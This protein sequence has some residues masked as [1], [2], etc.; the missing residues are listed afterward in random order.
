MIKGEDPDS[1]VIILLNSSF[2]LSY[3]GHVYSTP[4]VSVE[5]LKRGNVGSQSEVRVTYFS[6]N[7]YKRAAKALGIMDDFKAGVPRLAYKG[8]VTF[9][10]GN[11]R[12]YLAPNK[13]WAGYD[14][15]WS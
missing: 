4:V 6:S 14:P 7:D 15:K 10:R 5:D 2:Y 9:L 1:S 12:V 11:V 8:I 3:V 13:N